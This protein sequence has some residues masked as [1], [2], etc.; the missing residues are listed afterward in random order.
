MKNTHTLASMF[1]SNKQALEKELAG[2]VLPKD[3]NKIQQIV[4]KYLNSMFENDG[5]YRQ[6]LTQAEDYILQAALGLLN[7]QQS[8]VQEIIKQ[9]KEKDTSIQQTEDKSIKKN[10]YPYALAGTAVGG[11]LGTMLGTWGAVFGAIAGTAV[12]F[13]CATSMPSTTSKSVPVEKQIAQPTVRTEVFINIIKQICE[14]IDNLI[15]TFRT[16]IKRVENVYEQKE[17]PS[18]QKDYSML[19]QSIQELVVVA[20]NENEDKEKKLNRLEKKIND[21]SESLENYGLTIVD[22]KITEL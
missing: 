2:L 4:S 13:Y 20:Q 7:A 15:E 17:K 21:L 11:A 18:L 9:N 14:K 22:G 1:E 10:Q 5:E 16:Q 6:Q 8:I 12:V 19:L 3:A